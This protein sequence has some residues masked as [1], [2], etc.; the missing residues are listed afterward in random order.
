MFE[1]SINLIP[2]QS[3][4]LNFIYSY[5]PQIYSIAY[6]N[7]NLSLSSTVSL[8]RHSSSI[9]SAVDEITGLVSVVVNVGPTVS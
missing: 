3:V 6:D 4:T 9:I 2:C 7:E 8:V 1:V 5:F